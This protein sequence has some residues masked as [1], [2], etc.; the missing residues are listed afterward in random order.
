M[1]IN[2]CKLSLGFDVIAL[3]DFAIKDVMMSSKIEAR[4]YE[5]NEANVF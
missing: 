5:N 4:I 3:Y 2:E 1:E